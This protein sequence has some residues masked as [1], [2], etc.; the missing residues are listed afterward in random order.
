[1]SCHMGL[2]WFDT[3]GGLGRKWQGKK[4]RNLKRLRGVVTV[5]TPAALR[6]ISRNLNVHEHRSFSKKTCS[7]RLYRQLE[8]SLHLT[9]DWAV[10]LFG[11][12][13]EGNTV[14]DPVPRVELF[15]TVTLN[16]QS[17]NAMTWQAGLL[18]IKREL[19]FFMDITSI[20]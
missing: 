5:W 3:R 4:T 8:T 1:M 11:G 17:S 10:S 14:G 2:P 19:C 6:A 15:W 20:A 7:R 12:N 9:E 13:P 16:C 18:T